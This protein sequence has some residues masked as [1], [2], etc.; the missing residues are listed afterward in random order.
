MENKIN[1]LHHI[2]VLASN[3]Q[4]NYDFY[5]KTLGLRFVKKTVNF[6]APDVY[7]FYFADELGSPGTILTFFPFPL[8]RQ[9]TRG[10]GEASI[11]SF[12]IPKGSLDFWVERFKSKDIPYDGPDNKIDH[13][14]IS[15]L[16]PDGMM[17]EF[18]EAD[19]AHFT[20]WQTKDIPREHS[21]R[22]FFG[23]TLSLSS[24]VATEELITKIMGFV[25]HS[26]Q[27]SIKRYISGSG[28]YQA[29]LDIKVNP[30]L[31][32][33]IQSAGSVH[34]IAWRTESDESQQLWINRLRENGF[35]A[36]DAIDRNY[37][38]SIYFGTPAGVL[39]EIATDTP[40][41]MVDEEKETL[42][43][44][45]KLPAQFE[46]RREDIERVLIPIK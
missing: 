35:Q 40:G 11:V 12:S 2:T 3:P 31:N 9:G 7:H 33:A 4:K 44:A 21:I 38:H 29:F 19:V 36:T 6:D 5:T 37:F 20:G 27:N 39:F 25:L 1:G 34:H 23:T 17:I 46:S 22:K 24:S 32:R 15:L 42:G 26:E 10:N 45:L 13:D 14:Y 28:D 41:F 43:H 30:N 16:D 18:V 8:A